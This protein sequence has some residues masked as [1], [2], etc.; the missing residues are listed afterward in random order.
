MPGP[1]GT[2]TGAPGP[3]P[4]R[5][6]AP[7][8]A[9]HMPRG[10]HQAGVVPVCP[11]TRRAST[12]EALPYLAC[13]G[14]RRAVPGGPEG[15]PASRR[16]VSKAKAA[17]LWREDRRSGGH[18]APRS[19]PLQGALHPGR[20]PCGERGRLGAGGDVCRLRASPE[21]QG[22]PHGAALREYTWSADGRPSSPQQPRSPEPS[23]TVHVPQGP[24]PHALPLP[25]DR[26]PEPP[27]SPQSQPEMCHEA[28]NGLAA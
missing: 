27:A 6:A 16:A 11:G 19:Q 2:W 15:R 20:D 9:G 3:H 28:L 10:P 21:A 4:R 14:R 25:R 18:T 8:A 24:A 17:A 5:P 12:S 26:C 7:P 22:C 23:L 13:P 1:A